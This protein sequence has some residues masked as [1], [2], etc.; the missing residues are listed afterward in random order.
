[1]PWIIVGVFT[2]GDETELPVLWGTKEEAE[3][4]AAQTSQITP[5]DMRTEVR[6]VEIDHRFQLVRQKRH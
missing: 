6:R 3:Q 5:L 4:I 1:M 2:N